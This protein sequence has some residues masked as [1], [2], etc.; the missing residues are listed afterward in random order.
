MSSASGNVYGNLRDS[1]NC[2]KSFSIDQNMEASQTL[3]GN[4]ANSLSDIRKLEEEP[5]MVQKKLQVYL[6]MTRDS[7][8]R[9]VRRKKERKLLSGLIK[10][11]GQDRLTLSPPPGAQPYADM[12]Y[13]QG[14]FKSMNQSQD[15]FRSTLQGPSGPS[16]KSLKT[17]SS[18]LS[19]GRL[20]ATAQDDMKRRNHDQSY[21]DQFKSHDHIQKLNDA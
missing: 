1:L 2:S 8:I 5:S 6:N 17:N 19:R 16:M 4:R 15:G 21:Q 9:N 12:T 13:G 14:H 11:Q 20:T 3:L 7:F 18:W 10:T